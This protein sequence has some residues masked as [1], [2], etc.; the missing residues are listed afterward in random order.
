MAH[1][2]LNYYASV[3][4]TVN[5]NSG[6]ILDYRS[7]SQNHPYNLCHRLRF[8]GVFIIAVDKLFNINTGGGQNKS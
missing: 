1:T 3:F 7:E 8:L 6:I 4:G 2:S 5:S